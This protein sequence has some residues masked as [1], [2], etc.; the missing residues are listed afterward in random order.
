L[1]ACRGLVVRFVDDLVPEDDRYL[2]FGR[3]SLDRLEAGLLRRL[4]V[5]LIHVALEPAH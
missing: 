4:C 3:R 2:F 1:P 5:D